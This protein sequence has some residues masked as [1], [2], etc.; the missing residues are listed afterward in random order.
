MEDFYNSLNK[1]EQYVFNQYKSNTDLFCYNLNDALRASNYVQYQIEISLLDNMLIKYQSEKP[2]VLHRAT[3]ERNV[4]PFIVGNTYTNPEYLS[5]S[6]EL[7]S[8]E[9]HFTFTEPQVYIVF[10]CNSGTPMMPFEGNKAFGELEKEWV[11]GRNIEFCVCENEVIVNER[12]IAELLGLF[13]AHNIKS[14]RK[15]TVSNINT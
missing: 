4:L 14:L 15:I 5:T 3:T 6:N 7:E 1:S 11:I 13:N 8:I 9:T 2:K 12:E 10:H